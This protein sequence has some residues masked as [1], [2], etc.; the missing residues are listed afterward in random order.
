[1]KELD[2]G[3]LRV[4][5]SGAV[6]PSQGRK[7]RFDRRYWWAIGAGAAIGLFLFKPSVATVQT[8]QIVTAWPSQEH[9]LLNA[10]GYV[11]ARRK[12]AVAPKGTG[13]VEW[14]GVSEGDQVKAGTVI[15][16]LESRDVEASHQAAVANT[17]VASAAL[18]TA[19]SEFEDAQ[20]NLERADKLFAKRLVSLSYLQDAK[21]RIARADA[22]KASATAAIAA[23]RANE[24]YARSGVEYTRITAPFDGMVISRTADV[25]DIVTPLSSAADAKGAVLVMAD[26]SSLEVDA[27]VSESSLSLVHAGLPCEI[28]LDAFPDKRFRG[29]VSV[30]VPKVNRAS[31]T[32]TTKVRILDRDPGILPDMSAR[33]SFLSQPAAVGQQSLLAVNPQAIAERDGH[34][35]VYALA[36]DD[37]VRAV[38][39]TLGAVLGSVRAISGLL[40]AGDSVVL[41]PGTKLRDGSRIARAGAR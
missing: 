13:R 9:V 20:R 2:L 25:G 10:T 6:P 38:P 15:A 36:G 28:V 1:M 40:Q 30:V 21:S 22:G 8:T 12:A 16:R 23:A 19:R 31:A 24:S 3:K 33:V 18:L 14:L 34:S 35:L 26:M 27:E 39:V 11:V 29:E 37:R 17:A 4:D 41:E 32:V 5:R 7:R